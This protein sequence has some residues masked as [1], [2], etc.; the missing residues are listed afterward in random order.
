MIRVVDADGKLV[1]ASGKPRP[2][3][4]LTDVLR[5]LDRKKHFLVQVTP[6][7]SDPTFEPPICRVTRKK[8]FYASEHARQKVQKTPSDLMKQLELN[9]AI[10]GNDLGHRLNKMVAF[11]EEGRR[12]E[13]ILANKRRG[14]RAT[15]EDA[16]RVLKEIRGAVEK[17]QG[18]REWRVMEG[19]VLGQCILHFEGK[20]RG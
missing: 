8:D 13:V 6:P 18:A 15:E 2:P 11:L 3:Q 7:S 19:Q 14:R 1:D 12:V 17:V 20:E 5:S 10:D 4:S 16:R 9:W